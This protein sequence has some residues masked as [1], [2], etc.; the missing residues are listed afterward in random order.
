MKIPM[1]DFMKT[2][3][4]TALLLVVL[5]L[6]SFLVSCTSTGE[7]MPLAGN[8]T[9]IGT[10]QTTFFVPSSFFFMKKVKNTINVQAYI[11]LIEAAGQKYPGVIDLR[12]IVW[13]TGNKSFDHTK[14]EIFATSKVVRA[15]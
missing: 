15:E 4:K 12:D 9:I 14:T 3:R 6:T 8:E 2:L 7:Y 10:V 11:L 1:E 13:V 5:L